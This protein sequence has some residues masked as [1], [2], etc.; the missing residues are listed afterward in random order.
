[1]VTV[2][3]LISEPSL[4]Q[5]TASPDIILD[6]Y[7][8]KNGSGTFNATGGTLPYT[9]TYQENTANA[10]FAAPGFNSYSFF[11]AEQVLSL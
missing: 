1:M 8:D 10:T 4:L 9:F 3:V 6:C 7:N 5:L 2:P 11:N